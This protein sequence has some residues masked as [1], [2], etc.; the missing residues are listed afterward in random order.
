MRTSRKTTLQAAALCA[1]A[2]APQAAHAQLDLIPSAALRVYR[3]SNVFSF[4][5]KA[6]ATAIN[7]SEDM[8]DTVRRAQAG[9]D[10]AY[11]MGPQKFTASVQGRNLDY[12]RFS[13]LNHDEYLWRSAFDWNLGEAFSGR[14]DASQERRMATLADRSTSEL[15]L[16]RERIANAKIVYA[17][18]ERWR[19]ETT[20]G[21]SRLESPLPTIPD[22][23]LDQKIGTVALLRE[24]RGPLRSGVFVEY[25]DGRFDGV[26]T[27]RYFD[28][29]KI[30]ATTSYEISGLSQ[31]N[32]RLGRTQRNQ[33]DAGID[34]VSA[35][36][37]ELGLRRELSGVSA[38]GAT[39]FR[40]ISNYAAGTDSLVETGLRAALDWQPSI[41]TVAT[42]VE[43]SRSSFPSAATNGSRKDKIASAYLRVT[44]PVN[45]WLSIE[46]YAEARRRDSS[47]DDQRYKGLIGGIELRVQ[48]DPR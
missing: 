24:G 26:T 1:I 42:G 38:V 43:Y 36:T 4:A 12:Q 22:F 31:L 5:D 37:G 3:D 13:Q 28:Q 25:I 2:I 40:R 32:G 39:A 34:D 46:P 19:L 21:N 29:V 8:A 15:M 33:H 7:G 48:F 17:V 41:Y 9:L 45:R 6:E 35:F 18:S 23:A 14:F 20:A 44:Y 27:G 16:E 11:T 10:L 30:E 47:V